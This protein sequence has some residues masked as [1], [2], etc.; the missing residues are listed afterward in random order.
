LA[1]EDA[2]ASKIAEYLNDVATNKMELKVPMKHHLAVAEMIHNL[3][4]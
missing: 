4:T 1:L 2:P 3:K